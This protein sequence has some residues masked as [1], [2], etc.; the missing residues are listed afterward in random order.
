MKR[1]LLC[2]MSLLLC[3][4]MTGCG[5]GTAQPADT[6]PKPEWEDTYMISGKRYEV[7]FDKAATQNL[8]GFERWSFPLGNGYMGINVFGG[9]DNELITVTENSVFNGTLTIKETK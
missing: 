1:K 4:I 5:S 2:I 8:D 9:T 7:W 6:D 3:I